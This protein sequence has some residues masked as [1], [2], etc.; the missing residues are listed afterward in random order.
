M[1][2]TMRKQNRFQVTEEQRERF[3]EMLPQ[4]RRQALVAYRGL[5][6]EGPHS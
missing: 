4:I 1:I 2:A 3:L 6:A 5:G